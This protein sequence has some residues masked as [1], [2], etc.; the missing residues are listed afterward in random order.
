M[1]THT[2]LSKEYPTTNN[3]SVAVG[4]TTVPKGSVTSGCRLRGQIR[5]QSAQESAWTALFL[6]D[7]KWNPKQMSFLRCKPN[8]GWATV[9]FLPTGGFPPKYVIAIGGAEI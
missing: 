5:S 9:A 3:P 7:I 8:L 4:E 6:L 2:H 1:R